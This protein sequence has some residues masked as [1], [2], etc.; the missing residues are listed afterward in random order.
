MA[1]CADYAKYQHVFIRAMK[2]SPRGFENRLIYVKR[3][4]QG[5]IKVKLSQPLAD[6]MGHTMRCVADST[7]TI[8]LFGLHNW[9]TESYS[10]IAHYK[11]DWNEQEK[12]DKFFSMARTELPSEF[13]TRE[14]TVW[15]SGQALDLVYNYQNFVSLSLARHNFQH[16]QLRNVASA[17]RTLTN[18]NGMPENNPHMMSDRHGFSYGPHKRAHVLG[19]LKHPNADGSVERGIGYYYQDNSGTWKSNGFVLKKNLNRLSVTGLE[20]RP[21]FYMTGITPEAQ[22][23]YGYYNY[24]QQKWIDG[25]VVF[26]TDVK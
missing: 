12:Q 5:H 10:K 11:L 15:N 25:G 17:W 2:M 3:T 14:F 8:H 16:G 24:Q 22:V 7:N 20:A 4:P 1:A 19:R 9:A 18:N 23:G 13:E 21:I 26:N 6:D